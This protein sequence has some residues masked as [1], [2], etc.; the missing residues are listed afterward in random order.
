[1]DIILPLYHMMLQ[2][3][4]RDMLQREPFRTELAGYRLV[5]T[6]NFDSLKKGYHI[7]YVTMNEELKTAGTL[8]RSDQNGSWGA[9]YLLIMSSR[10]WKLKF[11]KNFV[12]YKEHV[13][14]DKVIRMFAAGQL[15][16]RLKK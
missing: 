3:I 8:I 16:F 11:Q 7:K 5:T 2:E 6:D 9:A 14:L 15:Q 1:M 13:T 4:V 12:F 10:P